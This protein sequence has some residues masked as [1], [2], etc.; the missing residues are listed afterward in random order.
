MRTTR[1][2]VEERDRARHALRTSQGIDKLMVLLNMSREHATLRHHRF[3]HAR[4]EPRRACE[5][6]QRRPRRRHLFS[7][8]LRDGGLSLAN[9]GAA[10]P[11]L[12]AVST[13]SRKSLRPRAWRGT[14]SKGPPVVV[15]DEDAAP[16]V[17]K[18]RNVVPWIRLGLRPL[19]C[20]RGGVPRHRPK[21]TTPRSR[22][23]T[24][25]GKRDGNLL[26]KGIAVKPAVALIL[27]SAKHQTTKGFMGRRLPHTA[28]SPMEDESRPSTQKGSATPTDHTALDDLNISIPHG[29]T[30]LLGQNGAGK[31]HAP[32][33]H[34]WLDSSH[35]PAKRN[36]VGLR[37]PYTGRGNP[38]THWLHA[39][40]RCPEP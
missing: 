11:S 29:A 33:N 21:W 23:C 7:P 3:G 31:I 15:V 9:A 1:L 20:S 30:G 25:H 32:Q 38:P 19:A 4:R 12:N 36:G 26:Q 10:A 37:H 13:R 18:G 6:H 35:D 2:S 34:S 5:E 14:A 40:I 17:R 39:G 16:Y 8:R 22:T 24:M 27:D 28:V